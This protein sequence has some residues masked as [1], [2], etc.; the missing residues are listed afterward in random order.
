[1]KLMTQS[2][3]SVSYSPDIVDT[4]LSELDPMNIVSLM[5][6]DLK[7]KFVNIMSNNP[8]K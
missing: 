7:Y 1:M 8:I 4:Y 6:I 3:H 2:N 5:D